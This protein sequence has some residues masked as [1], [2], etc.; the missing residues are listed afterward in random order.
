METL[1][2][3][4]VTVWQTVSAPQGGRT[5]PASLIPPREGQNEAAMS[6]ATQGR[7]IECGMTDASHQ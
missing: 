6:D 7:V 3:V 5:S 4:A 1:F 2:T